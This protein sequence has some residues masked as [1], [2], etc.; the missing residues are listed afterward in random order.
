MKSKDFEIEKFADGNEPVERK[1]KICREEK[2]TTRMMYLFR[3]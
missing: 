2:S 1:N 3:Q